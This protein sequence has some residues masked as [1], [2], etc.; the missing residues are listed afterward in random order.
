MSALTRPGHGRPLRF[1]ALVMMGWIAVR[2][3]ILW[4]QTGSLGRAIEQAVPLPRMALSSTAPPAVV[5]H[6][7]LRTLARRASALPGPAPALPPPPAV[8]RLARNVPSGR[9]QFAMLSLIGFG[10]TLA[11]PAQDDAPM[12]FA[13]AHPSLPTAHLPRID[14]SA[15]LL[16]RSGANGGAGRLG[17]S[18][19]GARLR[20]AVPGT[21]LAATTTLSAPLDSAGKE[22]RI[23]VEWQPTRAPVRVVADQ[24]VALDGGT[25]GGAE[26][27]LIGGINPVPV[28]GG[29]TLEGYG[30]GGAIARDRIE[31]YADLSLRVTRPGPKLGHAQVSLGAGLWAGAQREA[32]RVD[33]GPTL[34]TDI[35]VGDRH[36]RLA[37]DWRQRVGGGAAPGSGPALTLATNF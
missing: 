1:V 21:A 18:Q 7:A 2:I 3:L 8:L 12:P 30:Q 27:A 9:V 10:P 28:G 22:A 37:V 35:P 32:Q 17:G 6:V 34:V 16:S 29:L 11:V 19:A 26:L 13:A 5:P 4:P 24:R 33:I 23:G 14:G 20:L 25:R 31:P 15:W 36:L